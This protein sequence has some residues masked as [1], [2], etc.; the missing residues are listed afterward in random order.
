MTLTTHLHVV[1]ALLLLLGISHAFFNRYFGWE[2]ELETVSL[3]TRQV[4]HVHSFFIGLGVVLAGAGSLIYADAL[5]QPG[6][7]NRAILAA[8]AI[9][10]LCRLL[11]QFLAYD[12]AIWR[13]NRF[14]TFMHAAFALLW[15]YVTATYGIALI[16]VCKWS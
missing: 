14:R 12:A 5:L 7:L 15:C 3:L 16:T 8:M 11:A 9:F 10:W 4:F 2:Q 6:A 13:G 1:G